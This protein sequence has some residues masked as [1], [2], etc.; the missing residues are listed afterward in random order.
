MA[1]YSPLNSLSGHH[2][3]LDRLVDDILDDDIDECP[4]EETDDQEDE[5][6]RTNVNIKPQ[7]C[8]QGKGGNETLQA[9]FLNNGRSSSG[10]SS[11]GDSRDSGFEGGLGS[12]SISTPSSSRRTT[13]SSDHFSTPSTMST[14]SEGLSPSSSSSDKIA[15]NNCEASSDMNLQ[16]S[17]LTIPGG[18]AFNSRK[19]TSFIASGTDKRLDRPVSISSFTVNGDNEGI[20]NN[21]AISRAGK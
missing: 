11:N 12:G 8:E 6:I 2:D 19:P 20:Y 3:H 7:K 15:S 13:T 14:A 1:T 4:V 16:M 18:F 17:P 21:E 10:S 9:C 5:L